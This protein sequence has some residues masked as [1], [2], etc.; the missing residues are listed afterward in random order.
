MSKLPLEGVRI[1][2][3]T[4]L[5]AGAKGARHLALYGAEMIHLEWKG[6]LDVLRCRGREVEASPVHHIS[7]STQD[8]RPKRIE[9]RRM[10]SGGRRPAAFRAAAPPP[11][12]VT[13]HSRAG[14]V[15]APPPRAAAAVKAWRVYRLRCYH[16]PSPRR[17]RA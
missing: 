14:R 15:P 17:T 2:D 10:A 9:F 13:H 7:S 1:L 16:P 8:N 6:K 12:K 3:F 11:P 5:N 4:W